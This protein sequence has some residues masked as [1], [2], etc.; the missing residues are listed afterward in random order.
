MIGRYRIDER[1]GEGAMA[2]VYRAH[3]PEIDRAIAIKVLKPE[4]RGNAEVAARFLREARAAGAL[5]HAGI[6]TIHDVGEAAGVPYIAMEILAGVPLDQ[7]IAAH[8]A[9]P[10]K[11]AVSLAAQV[12]R[13]LDYAHRAG[14]VHRDIKPSNIFLCDDGRTAKLLDFGIARV[15]EPDRVRAELNALRTQIGQVLGTPRYMSPEQALGLA[16]DHRSD[17]F[18]LGVVLYEMLTGR[19][20]FDGASLATLAIQITRERPQPLSASIPGCPKGLHY[21]VARLLEKE[22]G[23]RFATGGDAADALERELGALDASNQGRGMSLKWRLSLA[24]TATMGFALLLATWA[25]LN[26]QD[27]AVETMALAS[28]TTI[29]RFVADNVGLRAVENAG[30]PVAQQDWAPVQA[31]V[32]AAARGP[33]VRQIAVVDAGGVVRSASQQSLIGQ[34]RPAPAEPVL[35]DSGEE[36]ISET[37]SDFRF[38]RTIAYAGQPFGT[39]EV[40]MSGDTSG[41]VAREA[42]WLLVAL[43]LAL[44]ALIAAIGHVAAWALTRPLRRLTAA[45]DDAAAGN[46]C[47]R[48]SHSRKD[49]IGALFD[50]YNGLAE[51]LEA[52]PVAPSAPSLEATRIAAADDAPAPTRRSA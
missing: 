16:V 7:H 19:M 29:S 36:R 34:R 8:G 27:S 41:A 49:E 28:G 20:A 13:A 48:F 6:V 52:R 14:I 21:L 24:M 33:A 39:V 32:D 22:P 9:L 44:L 4:L 25:V 40:V 11:T 46:L 10:L 35:V 43:C 15:G 30:L 38:R 37:G 26:R 45:L 12:S 1:I 31:F 2:D 3:D 17:L 51:A 42:R 50:A 23:K 5:S 47:F 18:S